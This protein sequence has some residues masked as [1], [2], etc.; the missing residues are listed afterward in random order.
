M[1]VGIMDYL[2]TYT[3]QV[4]EGVNKILDVNSR[5]VIVF[6]N[7]LMN[8]AACYLIMRRCAES[9]DEQIEKRVGRKYTHESSYNEHLES[10]KEIFVEPFYDYL[11]ENLDDKG[12]ILSL[13]RHYKHKCEWFQRD[14]LYKIWSSDTQRGEKK[15]ALHLYEYLHEHGVEFHIEPSSASGEADLVSSQTRDEPLIADAKIFNGSNK[16]SISKGFRQLYNYTVDYNEP[17]GFLIIYKTCEEDLK[18]VLNDTA[19]RTPF[20]S[21]NNKTIFFITIDIFPYNK[22]AS[23]RG[24]LHFVEVTTPDLLRTIE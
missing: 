17:F 6:D 20:L 9:P 14:S 16:D 8:A 24:V 19:Q 4:E 13:L 15:L 5:D 7:E 22:P 23:K 3:P 21:H 10:F 2:E 12:F 18:F 11:D 1:L